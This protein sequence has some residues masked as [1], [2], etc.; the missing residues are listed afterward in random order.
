LRVFIETM[1]QT[2]TKPGPEGFP[3]LLQKAPDPVI[4]IMGRNGALDLGA[5]DH[6]VKS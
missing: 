1:L 6:T 2:D 5:A 4:F 3:R